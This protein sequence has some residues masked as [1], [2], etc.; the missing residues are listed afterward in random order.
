MRWM[1][2][3]I[4][5]VCGSLAATAAVLLGGCDNM[6]Q[7]PPGFIAKKL[8]PTGWEKKLYESGMVNVGTKSNDGTMNILVICE[9]TTATIKE[10]FGKEAAG[11]TDAE[12]H[13][14]LTKDGVPLTVDVYVRV[15]L[16]DDEENRNSIFV[17]VTPKATPDIQVQR[18]L[19]ED[20]YER[21]AR[22]N[23]RSGAR[24]IF[25]E[26]DSYTAV[27]QNF[28]TISDKVGALVAETFKNAKVPLRLQAVELSNVK[29]DD[30]IWQANAAKA[31]ADAEV[32]RIKAIG[33]SLKASPEYR[34][35]MM[36]KQL[37]KIAEVG[38]KTGLN[39]IIIVPVGGETLGKQIAAAEYLRQQVA[40]KG[41]K[42]VPTPPPPQPEPVKAEKP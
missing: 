38:S 16:P 22:P 25:A 41:T 26:Q 29:P 21:F 33:D 15:L 1:K 23:I 13:R 28:K 11:N 30:I 31:S 40:P 42:I 3:L 24:A 36:W 20:V 37:E 35:Y 10:Q 32:N 5:F 4:A 7:V 39:T 8:T 2:F 19:L 12:D 9:A 6:K 34:E 27:Y 18:I 14:M 17:M